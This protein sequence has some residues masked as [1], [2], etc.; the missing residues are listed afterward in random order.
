V[1]G[2]RAPQLAVPLLFF[3]VLAPLAVLPAHA[4]SRGP[5]VCVY[6]YVWY[7]GPDHPWINY[8]DTPVLGLYN[9]S[10]LSVI[11]RHLAWLRDLGVDCLIIS[12]WGPGHYTDKVAQ[13]VFELLPSY[14]L[15]AV[16]FVEPYLGSD[17]PEYY[18]KTWWSQTLAYIKENYIDKYPESYLYIDGKP[19]VPAFN[20]I[21][22]AYDPRPDFPQYAIRIVGNDI[23]NAK[24]QDWD[25][26][27]DYD[28]GLTGQL[29]IRRDG[30]VAIAPRYDDEHFRPG[31][32]PPYDPDLSKGWYVKQWKYILKHRSEIGVIAI[33]TWNEFHERTMIEPHNDATAVEKDPY[34][35]YSLTQHYIEK[36]REPS[37]LLEGASLG[38]AM[39]LGL[40]LLGAVVAVLTRLTRP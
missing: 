29:R 26:W 1:L 25:Y 13:K 36:L 30:Y 7:G 24:Y 17:H 6:Y 10:H 39:A 15:K 33:A 3:L 9:S 8:R 11:A 20:P 35:L 40:G 27:P 19:L 28:R 21:G 14:G 23:D 22:L 2:L 32:V 18:N 37:H 31:G 12:W 34:Y 16:I 5:V 38:A 4:S